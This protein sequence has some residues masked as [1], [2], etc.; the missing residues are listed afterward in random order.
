MPGP[1]YLQFKNELHHHGIKG[2]NGVLRMDRRIQLM[3]KENR[4]P[5][6]LK[7]LENGY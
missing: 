1:D 3:E 5:I 2:Q 6:F 4:F 7:K